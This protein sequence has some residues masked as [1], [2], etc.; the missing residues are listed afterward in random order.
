MEV[1]KGLVLR[2]PDF[3]LPYRGFHHTMDSALAALVDLGVAPSRVSVRMAGRGLPSC[4]IVE[5]SPRAN[6]I[7]SPDVDVSLSVAGLGFFHGLPVGMW[8]RG[9]EA[10]IGTQELVELLDDPIQKAAYWFRE[11]ARLFDIQPDN[12]EACRRWISL[13]GLNPD[14][15]PSETW[16]RLS[17]LLPSL[18][19]LA[20]REAGIRLAFQL[21]VGL[22]V[23]EIRNRPVFT[24]LGRADQTALGTKLSRLG[25]DCIVG[26]R[27]ED[28]SEISLVLGPV[29]LDTYYEFELEEN[30]RCVDGL[31]DLC[32]A[33]HQRRTVGLDDVRQ[34][35]SWIVLDPE[36]APRLGMA[37]DNAVLG[38]NSY[39]GPPQPVVA[40][41]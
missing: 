38:I 24:M 6:V 26:D 19:R 22:P 2:M 35:I 21:L 5:Q 31:L 32:M 29:T 39:L 41:Q 37:R 12:P 18:H 25:V 3:C 20:G 9:G 30:R 28:A 15:W 27:L 16:Y 40:V 23:A 10:G 34:R 8:Y 36:K 33:C 11:G 13:F 7:L 17:L 1:K 14:E 4:W